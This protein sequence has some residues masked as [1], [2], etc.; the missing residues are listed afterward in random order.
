[1]IPVRDSVIR[2]F[3]PWAYSWPEATFMRAIVIGC[4][5]YWMGMAGSVTYRHL[6]SPCGLAHWFD[7]TWLG[8]PA[9]RT[10]VHHGIRLGMGLYALGAVWAFLW[11]ARPPEARPVDWFSL[12]GLLLMTLGHVLVQTNY[13]SFGAIHHSYTG[14]A[15]VLCTQTLVHAWA[16]VR[17]G[18]RPRTGDAGGLSWESWVIY[19]SSQT[20]AASYVLAGLAKLINTG[21]RWIWDAPMIAVH[22][23]RVGDETY[24]DQLDPSRAAHAE[25]WVG[26]FTDHPWLVRIGLGGSLILELAAI[27]ALV[28]PRWAAVVGIACIAM[29]EG[30]GE[31]MQLYFGLCQLLCLAFWV[32]P[33]RWLMAG[34]RWFQARRL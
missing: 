7:L 30:I 28:G 19:F 12:P 10:L 15:L 26:F 17:Q 27:L 31:M 1:M 20:L 13:N 24:Y 6:P 14:L 22:I 9:N 16:L 23:A 4:L 25:R 29:H 8:D 33:P 3:R 21:P 11:R 34:W 2:A 5:W 32:N 18:L